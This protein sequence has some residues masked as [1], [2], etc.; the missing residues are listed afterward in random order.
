MGLT[1]GERKAAIGETAR[2]ALFRWDP[3]S[4]VVHLKTGKAKFWHPLQLAGN[5]YAEQKEYRR[6]AVSI[7]GHGVFRAEKYREE[8]DLRIFKRAP[9]FIDSE[10]Q[11]GRRI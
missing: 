8:R 5:F 6:M 9:D 11:A 7:D 4:C 3:R 1:M 10:L 2:L